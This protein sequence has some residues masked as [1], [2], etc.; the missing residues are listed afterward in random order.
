MKLRWYRSL[1]WRIALGVVGFL[2]V[3]LLVQAL[4]FVF[5]ISQSGRSLPGQS[6][7]RL[8]MTVALDL[9]NQLER[10]P[11]VD[12][13][14][15]IH[16]QYAQYTHPFFVM[17]TDGK[18]ITSGSKTFS[19]SLMQMARARIEHPFERPFDRA[20]R[21]EGSPRFGAGPRSER[22]DGA[23]PDGPRPDGMRPDGSRDDG[24]PEPPAEGAFPERPRFEGPRA[25]GTRPDRPRG[26]RPAPDIADRFVRDLGGGFAIPR[27]ILVA[28]KLVGV[29]VVPPQAPFGFLLGRFAPMLG[30]IAGGVLILGAVMT[31]V[32]IF[33][34]ARRRLRALESAAHKLGAGDLSVRAPS[35]GGD[36]I[37][38][39]A[40]AF[41]AM[42]GDLS[43][44]AEALSESDRVRRQLLADVS[45]ELTTPVTAMRGYLETLTMPE[46][47]LDAAT[48]ARYLNIISDE[49]NRLERL[50]G[51]LLDLARL[52]GGGGTLRIEDVPVAGLFDRVVARHGPAC[53]QAGITIATAIAPGAEI[54]SG[55]RDRLE[56]AVQNLAA[57]AIRYAPRGTS[58]RL[59]A[60]PVDGDAVALAV[61]DAG[62]TGITSEHLPHV[63]DRFY[64]AD[65]SRPFDRSKGGATDADGPA[66][67]SG[68]SGLGLSIVKAIVERHG[69]TISIDSRPGRTV[70]EMV[71]PRTSP[72]AETA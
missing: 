9:A 56:Q 28:G 22:P 19:D 60:R 40:S 41:N 64:K 61:E 37:A 21:P 33:G 2:A 29:V 38:A 16:E 8:G 43:A 59:S 58:V 14:K 3:M 20:R 71:L 25:E 72:P 32:M 13:T 52:E 36:E 51:D 50:I 42:A 49:T 24:A 46:L 23:R 39:V 5:A 55:D 30:L 27:S 47:T 57:N 17:L 69:G 45:H 53:Q 35:K 62:E 10:D 6:P 48:R 18:V 11:Q 63:F 34:P 4:M 15:Y 31:S 44:R 68:G 12:L 26:F 70:F 67:A 1:Y 65:S 54:V 7:D 66:I